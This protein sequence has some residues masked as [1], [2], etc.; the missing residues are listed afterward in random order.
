[1][2][3]INLIARSCSCS[4]RNS[5]LPPV[6]ESLPLPP[7]GGARGVRVENERINQGVG[8]VGGG[9]GGRDSHGTG[10]GV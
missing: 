7:Q 3:Q 5:L 1:M 10:Q 9:G 8:R 2:I 6:S 4:F